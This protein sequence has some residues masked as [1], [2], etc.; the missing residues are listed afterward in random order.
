ME[1]LPT[2]ASIGR[3]ELD[4]ALIRKT[5]SKIKLAFKK[6]MCLLEMLFLVSCSDLARKQLYTSHFQSVSRR[7]AEVALPSSPRYDVACWHAAKAEGLAQSK[8]WRAILAVCLVMPAF[9]HLVLA[10]SYTI[11]WHTIQ[12]KL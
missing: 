12:T 8:T 5:R 4:A 3:I 2:T 6:Q 11:D 10:Q 9:C 1:F 7:R